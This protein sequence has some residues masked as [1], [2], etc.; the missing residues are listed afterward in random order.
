MTVRIQDTMLRTGKQKNRTLRRVQ[1]VRWNRGARTDW[2]RKILDVGV[3]GGVDDV[4]HASVA[5][6]QVGTG[7]IAAGGH[8][9]ADADSRGRKCSG[10]E[11]VVGGNSGGTD[12]GL[13]V[14]A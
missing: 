2:S 11:G 14:V 8:G 5:T 3:V 1:G 6:R 10:T 4:D 9:Q 7:T 12:R 13:A